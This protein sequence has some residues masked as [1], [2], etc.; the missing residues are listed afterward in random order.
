[1]GGRNRLRNETKRFL[2]RAVTLRWRYRSRAI[3]VY[4]SCNFAKNIKVLDIHKCRDIGRTNL[5]W[6][7]LK[8]LISLQETIVHGSSMNVNWKVQ[9]SPNLLK[10]F[11]I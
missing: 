6:K 1:M 2:T 7:K 5:F 10:L 4:V 11:R 3:W 9:S 8:R